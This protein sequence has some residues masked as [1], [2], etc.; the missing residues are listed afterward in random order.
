MS[1]G[2][3]VNLFRW[4]ESEGYIRPS[5]NGSRDGQSVYAVLSHLESPG[6]ELIGEEKFVLR[7]IGVETAKA[8]W[9]GDLPPM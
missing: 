9:R 8:V 5:H 7:T 2:G 1:D 6:Y 3:T 4:A